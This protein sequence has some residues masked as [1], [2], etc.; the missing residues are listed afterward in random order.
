MTSSALVLAVRSDLPTA[1]PRRAPGAIPDETA[2]IHARRDRD[3]EDPSRSRRV[4]SG[5]HA[6]GGSRW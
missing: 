1:T 3:A 5:R 2:G 6:A 4:S